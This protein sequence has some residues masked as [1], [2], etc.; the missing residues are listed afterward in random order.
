MLVEDNWNNLTL[1]KVAG[2]ARMFYNPAVFQC[3]KVFR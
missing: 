2:I 3:K 1:A